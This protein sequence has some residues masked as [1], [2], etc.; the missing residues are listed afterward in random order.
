MQALTAVHAIVFINGIPVFKKKPCQCDQPFSSPVY[1]YIKEQFRQNRAIYVRLINNRT[2]FM[3]DLLYS[4]PVN[5]FARQ[6]LA[7]PFYTLL[8]L[9]IHLNHRPFINGQS[10]LT[11]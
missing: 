10:K 5:T 2:Q 4:R 8:G 9:S 7:Q 1:S 11:M 3:D 6:F